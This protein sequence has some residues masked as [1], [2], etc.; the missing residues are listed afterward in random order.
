[1][2]LQAN[3]TVGGRC[4]RDS[5]GFTLAE[6]L[7]ASV[8]ALTV[9]GTLYGFYRTQIHSLKLQ[10]KRTEVLETARA[11]MEFM[12]R[13]IRN[14]GNWPS[15]GGTPPPETNP[16]TDDPEA[17]ADTV[18]NRI[19]AATATSIRIQTDLNEDS[20][21]ADTHETILYQY[22]SASKKIIRNSVT[23]PIASNVEIPTGSDFMTYYS[24]GSTIPLTQPISD[25]STIKRVK[26]TFEVKV[27]DPTPQG[28]AAGRKI[29]TT[30]VSNVFFRNS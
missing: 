18:C 20:D 1:M 29:T 4:L 19:Y 13:E 9:L 6:L 25:L 23:S 12:V 8:F 26:I 15:T 21:C 30:L 24:A 7:V 22:N 11:A 28:K 5:R 2:F 14:A 3:D 16:T 17:D 27:D 10:E